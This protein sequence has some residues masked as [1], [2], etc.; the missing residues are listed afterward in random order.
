M[1]TTI[2]TI[3][4]PELL[5]KLAAAEGRIVFRGPA[6]EA[7]KTADTVTRGGLPPGVRSPISDEE[8]EEARK[9]PDGSPLADVWKR[10]HERHKP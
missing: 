8:I 2:I 10:I 4:D 3:T 7:I 6:G 5:A 1:T 9:Q